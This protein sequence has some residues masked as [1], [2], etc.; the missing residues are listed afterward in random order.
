VTAFAAMHGAEPGARGTGIQQS[1][2]HA[3][4]GV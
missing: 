4:R 1:P 2:P 3:G